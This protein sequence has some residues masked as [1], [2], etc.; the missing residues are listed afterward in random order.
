M[1]VAD[2]MYSF[3]DVKT[4]NPASVEL[5]EEYLMD[6]MESLL[7]KAYQRAIRRDPFSTKLLKDD[8]LYFLKDNSKVLARATYMLKI[9]KEFSRDKKIM[10]DM[11]GP[12]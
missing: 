9:E 7:M 11:G 1:I 8:L 12:S 6:Y 5:L 4:P 3:G 10:G 2:I